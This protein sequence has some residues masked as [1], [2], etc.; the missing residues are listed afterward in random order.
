MSAKSGEQSEQ[1]SQPPGKDV[2]VREVDPELYRQFCDRAASLG[3]DAHSVLRE[4]LSRGMSE[5]IR[6][7]SG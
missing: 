2:L 7:R 6:M 1:I 3:V 5:W 4:V